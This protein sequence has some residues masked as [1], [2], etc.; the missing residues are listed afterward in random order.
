M[1]LL[2]A[3]LH[4]KAEELGKASALKVGTLWEE[5]DTSRPTDSVIEAYAASSVAGMQDRAAAWRGLS[6]AQQGPQ[7]TVGMKPFKREQHFQKARREDSHVRVVS[8]IWEVEAAKEKRR[9]SQEQEIP[10]LLEATH[11][12]RLGPKQDSFVPES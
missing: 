2:C 8:N 11:H 6:L 1:H 7:W 4:W 9:F 12:Q 3:R 10:S 5:T